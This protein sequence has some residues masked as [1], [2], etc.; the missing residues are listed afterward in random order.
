VATGRIEWRNGR[1]SYLIE[2]GY[3]GRGRRLR[4]RYSPKRLG[5]PQPQTKSEAKRQLRAI[6]AEIDKGTFIEPTNMLL[7]EY[8]EYWLTNCAALRVGPHTAINYRRTLERYVIEDL[9]NLKLRAL[10]AVHVQSH[11]RY[12]LEDGA[13]SREGGLKPGSVRHVH[14]VLHAALEW[15]FRKRV[16]FAN[17]SD[18]P[19]LPPADYEPEVILDQ[20]G[21]ARLLAMLDGERL[22]E[23]VRAA[24]LTGCRRGEVIAWKWSDVDFAADTIRVRRS[25]TVTPAGPMEGPPKTK[26][27]KRMLPM[28]PTL[29][30]L[31]RSIHRRQAE[32][33]LRLG[34]AYRDEDWVFAEEDGSRPSPGA[35]SERYRRFIAKTEFRGL[36]FHDLR[37][38]VT[39]A[40]QDAGE[41][42]PE[43][44]RWMGWASERM[45]PTYSH[46]L[47]QGRTA[48][49]ALEE[50]FGHQSGTKPRSA[51]KDADR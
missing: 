2:Y 39:S 26:A 49:S 40:L 21:A 29:K 11:Y 46:P 3:D 44:A 8:L 7:K 22:G 31:L 25:L 48:V 41:P 28:G 5:L 9:G 13:L 27:G 4:R 37:H 18:K 20:A 50:A 32:E 16:I 1:P 30:S 15:A 17:P 14:R 12:L 19:D 38:S 45:I 23:I 35:V 33:K 34:P 42:P 36:R 51:S 47:R 24:L 43:I 10:T 6:L